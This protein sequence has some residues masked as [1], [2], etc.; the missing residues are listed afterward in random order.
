MRVL[1]TGGAG[2]IGS[3]ITEALIGRG[4]DVVVLDDMSTGR[5]ENLPGNIELIEADLADEGV[6]EESVSNCSAVIH[7][8]A[9]PSV[10]LSVENPLA[11]NRANLEATA[12]LLLACRSSGIR[13]MVYSSSS[14]VYGGAAADS[15]AAEN[16]REEPLSPYGMNKLASEQLCRMAPAL[17]GVDTACLRYFN[18]YGPRQD[19]SSPYSGVISIFVSEALQGRAPV[20]HG[21]GQQ[22]RDFTFVTDVVAANLAALDVAESGGTVANI[23]AGGVMNINQVWDA[24]CRACEVTDLIPKREDSRPGDVR[25]SRADV[26][27]AK[28]W[29]DWSGVVAFEKG[30]RKTVAWYRDTQMSS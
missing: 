10:A 1:V 25:H 8:A 29:L 4:D 24:V 13:R 21:D 6:A 5:H 19:P 17:W 30:I 7:C 26:S 9:K 15:A 28:A 2:F 18:V 22:T 3:H 27:K 12:R 14:A 16:M 23:G 20:I 11:S